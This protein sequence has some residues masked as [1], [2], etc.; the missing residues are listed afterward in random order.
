MIFW[1]VFC[2]VFR[3]EACDDLGG[4]FC[5]HEFQKNVY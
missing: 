3:G 1:T 5:E 2:R 4:A